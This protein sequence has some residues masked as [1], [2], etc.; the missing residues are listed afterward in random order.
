MKQYMLGVYHPEPGSDRQAPENMDEIFRDVDALNEEMKRNGAWV[1]GGGLH[2]SSTATVLQPDGDGVLITERI[3]G[4]TRSPTQWDRAQAAA[5]GRLLVAVHRYPAPPEPGLGPAVTSRR[6]ALLGRI[7]RDCPSERRV[8]VDAAIAALP[9]P[10][11]RPPALLHGDPWSGNLVWSPAGPILVDWEYARGGEPA[12]DLAY[13]AALDELADPALA[14]VLVGY[15]A[16]QTLAARVA[17]WR[18]LMA[19][20][21][22][23]WLGARGATDRGARLLAH[24]ERL[25]I[26]GGGR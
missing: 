5:V 15:G 18:P 2:P 21:C 4:T 1:F 23:V 22:G 20:W 19:A 25:L 14:A 6:D 9:A 10:A 11:A 7:Q 3:D 26:D 24:A 17:A 13:L 8:L 16:D 12:E